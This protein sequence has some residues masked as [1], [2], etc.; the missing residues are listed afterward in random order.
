MCLGGQTCVSNPNADQRGD[1]LINSGRQVIVP[2]STFNCNGRITN[3][4]VSMN[5]V[6]SGTDFSV[7]E[8]WH[9]TSPSGT[10]HKIGEVELPLGQRIGGRGRGNYDY[11]TL[12]LNSS[13]QIEFQSGDVIGYYQPSDTQRLIWS[14]QTTGYTSY[15]NNV[16][17]PSTSIDINNVDNVDTDH[18][19]LIEISFG[20]VFCAQMQSHIITV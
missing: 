15:S 4:I 7:F 9:P 6:S 11:A 8:V 16:T 12:S 10:Y 19:P 2:N 18:Q 13:T 3:I 5:T 20:K 14:I 1:M 17:S